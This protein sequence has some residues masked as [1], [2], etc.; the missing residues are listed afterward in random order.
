MTISDKELD[1]LFTYHAPTLEQQQRYVKIREAGK[2][3][4]TT[5]RDA[6]PSSADCTVAIRKVREAVMNAN[7]SIACNEDGAADAG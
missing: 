4:A 6:C 2:H 1:N 5:I 3:L 7:A